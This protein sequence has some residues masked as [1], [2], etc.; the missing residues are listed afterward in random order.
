MCL[1]GKVTIPESKAG[2]GYKVVRTIV[3][4]GGWKP[5][6]SFF[7]LGSSFNDGGGCF[8]PTSYAVTRPIVTYSLF[9]TTVPDR[10]RMT[11]ALNG[12]SYLAGIHLYKTLE[13][14]RLELCGSFREIIR[15]HYNKAIA[16]DEEVVVAMEVTPV[17]IEDAR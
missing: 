4:Q 8:E 15:C 14:A 11:V 17:G 5:L 12:E 2:Y 10:P 6:Y 1:R 3:A 13:L 9:R 16:E 7:K